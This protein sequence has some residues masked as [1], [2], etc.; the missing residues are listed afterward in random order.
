[1]ASHINHSHDS[2]ADAH[3]GGHVDAWHHHTAEEGEPQ[4]EH[5]GIAKT[6]VIFAWFL[7]GV[8]FLVGTIGV[9]IA[10]FDKYS[11]EQRVQLIEAQP[12]KEWWSQY[13][14]KRSEMVAHVA[15]Q[16]Y[17]LVD[18]QKGTARPPIDVTMR[19]VVEDYKK[20]QAAK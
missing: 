1:M 10:Y 12:A 4:H 15:P 11:T 9:I 5:G 18:A 6:G 14:A 19:R 3:G 13:E 16:G 17:E 8:I 20:L 7:G 2:H